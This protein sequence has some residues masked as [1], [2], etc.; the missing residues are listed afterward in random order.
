M[1]NKVMLFDAGGEQVGETFMR[2]ARQLVSQ[3]RAEWINEGAI[4]FAPD[5]KIEE[6][7]WT[8]DLHD[9][10]DMQ[11]D[12]KKSGK[13]GPEAL[14]YYIAE[15]RLH[16]R[17]MFMWHSLMM[18]PGYAVILVLAMYLGRNGEM[19]LAIFWAAWTTPYLM[20]AFGFIRAR[21]RE[22]HPENRVRQL[23]AEVDKLKRLME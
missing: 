12:T 1:K 13:T 6:A 19:F 15:Q 3:Q 11:V 21:M 17:K 5:A 22:Y 4:R 14:L 2:R 23:E 10:R 8:T 18:V 16:E 9:H 20:R 7:E